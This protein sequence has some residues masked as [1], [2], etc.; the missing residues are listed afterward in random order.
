M[1]FKGV[2]ILFA[3]VLFTS[4]GPKPS[5]SIGDIIKE[6]D[7]YISKVDANSNL[8]EETIEGALT[9]REGFKDIG[10]FKYTVYVDGQNN[11]LYKIKN[12]EMTDKTIFETYYFKEGELIFIDTNI[13]GASHKMYVQKNKVISETKTNAETQKLLLEKANRFQKNFNKGR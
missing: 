5:K 8:K 3:I 7:T 4:C 6:I 11:Q 12:V 9:D 2:Q 13:G 1:K 10:K